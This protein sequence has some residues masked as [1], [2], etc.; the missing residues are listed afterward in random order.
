MTKAFFFLGIGA[1]VVNMTSLVLL[2]IKIKNH[3]IKLNWKK[4]LW[5]AILGLML[6]FG[7][8]LI[9]YP[10]SNDIRIHGFPFV[11]AAFQ[12]E[13]D[14]RVDFIGPLTEFYTILNALVFF[15]L[16]SFALILIHYS[17]GRRD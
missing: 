2:I 13:G 14:H 12:L 8:L 11:A 17:R 7:S 1:V 6:A 5:L 4:A 3:Q 9:E 10:Y 15:L 16:P